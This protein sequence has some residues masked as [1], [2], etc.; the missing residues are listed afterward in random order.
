MHSLESGDF[1][2]AKVYRTEPGPVILPSQTCQ[3][4]TATHRAL[5]E[6]LLGWF[7]YCPLFGDLRLRDLCYTVECV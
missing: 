5:N 2:V 7:V 1:V 3:L 6:M 4:W